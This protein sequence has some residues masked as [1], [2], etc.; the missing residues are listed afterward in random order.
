MNGC[1]LEDGRQKYRLASERYIWLVYLDEKTKGIIE[2]IQ[3]YWWF[4]LYCISWYCIKLCYQK[5]KNRYI[6]RNKLGIF[7]KKKCLGTKDLGAILLWEKGRRNWTSH[8]RLN[9]YFFKGVKLS[10]HCK[11]VF[12]MPSQEGHLKNLFS[13]ISHSPFLCVISHEFKREHIELILSVE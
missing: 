6:T 8:N 3:Y 11:I 1:L 7:V 4:F 10:L 9:L 2:K 5:Q 12:T 13:N